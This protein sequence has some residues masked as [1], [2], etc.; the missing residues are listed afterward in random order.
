[1]AVPV[2]LVGS[3]TTIHQRTVIVTIG[4][5]KSGREKPFDGNIALVR[6][7]DKANAVPVYLRGFEGG[8]EEPAWFV[9]VGMC[10]AGESGG[11]EYEAPE[12]GL[13][14]AF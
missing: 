2:W 5:R 9:V 6:V 8:G 4:L 3:A 1:M 14:I 10:P 12:G 13:V 11:K 7:W